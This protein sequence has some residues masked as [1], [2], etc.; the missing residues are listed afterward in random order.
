M[1]EY[2]NTKL[3]NGRV[4]KKGVISDIGIF[5]YVLLFF[6][7]CWLNIKKDTMF[8]F[9]QTDSEWNT[10]SLHSHIQY[11]QNLSSL[12]KLFVFKNARVNFFVF[13][14]I[15]EVTLTLDFI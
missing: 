6:P 13:N 8:V 7:Q 10:F 2:L 1:L 5:E 9:F 12:V 4:Q 14:K 15:P 11:L 3:R